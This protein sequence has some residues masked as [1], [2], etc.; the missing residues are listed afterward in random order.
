MN[1]LEILL[2]S[3]LARKGMASK[4][5]VKTVDAKT[6]RS[7]QPK[8]FPMLPYP[9][10]YRNGRYQL[11]QSMEAA[12]GVA[13]FKQIYVNSASGSDSKN[14]LTEANAVKT[15]KK[16]FEIYAN[17]AGSEAAAIHILDAAT[18]TVDELYAG[19]L[20]GGSS[21]LRVKKPLAVIA[22][23]GAT[24]INGV[25]PTWTETET[26]GVYTATIGNDLTPVCIV[27]VSADN[28][29]RDGALEP[30]TVCTALAD[31]ES[32]ANSFYISGTTVYVHPRSGSTPADCAALVSQ[33]RFRFAHS[34][35]ASDSFL[36]LKGLDVVGR[37]YFVARSS[38]YPQ[39]S[40]KIE[41]FCD[42]CTFEHSSDDNIQAKSYDNVVFV[43][44]LSAFS[45]ADCFSSMED[46]ISGRTIGDG[47]V[48]AL[49]CRARGAGHY[50][51]SGQ[52]STNLFTAH[53]GE[54]VLRINC[55]GVDHAGP[56]F[57]DV[58]GCRSVL[59]GC[60][61]V[62]TRF[63]DLATPCAWDFNNTSAATPGFIS[64]Q[65]CVVS[66][67]RE[68]YPIRSTVDLEVCRTS[69]AGCSITGALTTFDGV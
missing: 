61:S 21:E 44:C 17:K 35:A 5:E 66:D 1:M 68:N 11:V 34:Q 31:C 38:G 29:G 37:T 55:H 8:R 14:G 16:A 27:E 62:N 41:L 47:V 36:L 54:N 24:V 4:A 52:T 65:D 51:T 53:N 56:A 6:A 18:F 32:T 49:N 39:L 67:L 19:N 9:V 23:V 22:D 28:R 50:A 15:L 40:Y 13:D 46:T 10:E 33:I 63:S 12:K 2:A 48:L 26:E 42:G 3:R 20:S 59:I 43:D 30:M 60:S 45:K 58:N 7:I 69:L 25:K 57:A 64:L